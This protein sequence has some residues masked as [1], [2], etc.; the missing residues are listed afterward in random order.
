MHTSLAPAL[1]LSA[2]WA[3]VAFAQDPPETPVGGVTTTEVEAVRGELDQLRQEIEIVR[4]EL[5]QERLDL[6]ELR[7]QPRRG[8]WDYD[9]HTSLGSSV[10]IALGET[11]EEVVAFGDDVLVSGVVE[12]DA[13]AFGG[14]I[15]I[16]PS[17]VIHGDAVSFGGEVV[18]EEGGRL[19]GQKVSIGT[20][21]TPISAPVNAKHSAMGSLS[22]TNSTAELLSTLYR[23]FILMLSFAGAGVLMVGVFPNRV[24][25]IA[26][27]LEDHPFRS[28]VVG[29]LATGFLTL[30][31]VLFAL[32]TLGLGIPVS[33]VVIA[34]LGV[35]WMMGF[36]G[37]CQAIGDR[38]PI[39]KK[40]R[41]RWLA[42]LMGAILVTCVGSLP[43]VGWLIV[44]ASSTL[45]IG[46]ALSSRLGSR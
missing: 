21:T 36:V 31:S 27:T 22:A 2:L 42:F 18:V 41:G 30:F 9:G 32:I 34:V 35:A 26:N 11:V 16:T 12:G 14:S 46:A 29:I 6:E 15:I 24:G 1:L 40:P 38:L 8:T 39:D 20:M 4:T 28:G 7:S 23:R 13:T 17:G 43:Q 37:L 25:R 3:P 5:T 19:H 10:N 33:M 44:M 45:G